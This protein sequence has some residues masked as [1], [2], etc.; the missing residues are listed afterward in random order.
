VQHREVLVAVAFVAGAQ[1]THVVQVGEGALDDPALATE[2]G[3]VRDAGL[4]I[5]G[6]MPRAQSSRRCLSKS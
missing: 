4:V 3:A 6:L 5:T 2:A 1:A